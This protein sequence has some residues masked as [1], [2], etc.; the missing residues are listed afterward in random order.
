MTDENK[1]DMNAEHPEYPGL[2]RAEVD[3]AKKRAAEKVAKARKS[4]ALDR[5]ADQEEENLR[6][7]LGETERTMREMENLSPGNRE[8]VEISLNLAPQMADIRIDGQIFRNR[9]TYKVTR[10]K[11]MDM[12]RMQFEG[13]RHEAIRKGD[14]SYAFYA[15]MHQSQK[16]PVVINTRLGIIQGAQ[17][18]GTH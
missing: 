2:T 12:L 15:Q 16:S 9:G 4:D 17:P 6:L 18:K 13:W 3:A 11:A 7:A 1:T 10:A 8:M 5:I 14:D